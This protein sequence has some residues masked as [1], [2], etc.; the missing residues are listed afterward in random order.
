MTTL[1]KRVEIPPGIE[2]SLVESVMVVKGPKGEIKKTMKYP[3]V[4]V[5]KDAG[6][7]V[8]GAENPKKRQWAII[9]T[10]EAHTKNMI[11]GVSLGFEYKMKIIYSHFPMSVKVD[12]KTISVENYLG[13]KVAR[14]TKIVGDCEVKVKGTEVVITGNN[15]E[16][17]GQTAANLEQH[18]KV[19][20]KD[21]RVFQDGIYLIEK[22]GAPV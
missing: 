19:K 11:K 8:I 1:E 5:R 10:Y 3:G 16:E 20:N 6:E 21:P 2:V 13:E 17:V 4:T 18:T 7:V 15:I 14:K 9:G 22:D 12:Q